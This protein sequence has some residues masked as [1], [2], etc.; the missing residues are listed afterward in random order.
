MAFM[1]VL[2][3]GMVCLY[4]QLYWINLT[5]Y[6]FMFI[7]FLILILH[8]TGEDI[9]TG[10]ACLSS[11]YHQWSETVYL[12]F[13]HIF[14]NLCVYL[15]YDRFV[16]NVSIMIE[17]CHSSV[18]Q[19][20]LL[21]FYRAINKVKVIELGNTIDLLISFLIHVTMLLKFMQVKRTN[22]THLIFVIVSFYG[23]STFHVLIF[24]IC[25]SCLYYLLYAKDIGSHSF[26]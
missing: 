15:H 11:V 12:V 16:F 13:F 2:L 14:F 23:Q 9:Q 3:I 19:I 18:K 5:S 4:L 26:D 20:L 8:V 24:F 21:M 10:R 7:S 25:F 17:H 6:G 22:I 1:I